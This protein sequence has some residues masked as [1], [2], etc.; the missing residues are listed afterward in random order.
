MVDLSGDGID[1]IISGSYWPGNLYVFRGSKD[2]SF[3]PIGVI[4]DGHRRN[5]NAGL[6]WRSAGE[7][8]LESLAPSPYVADVDADGAPDILVGNMCGT[9]VLIKNEG[10]VNRSYFVRKGRIQAGG[11][12]FLAPEG[13]SQPVMVDWD[14]DGLKDLIVG[15]EDGSVWFLRNTGCATEPVFERESPLVEGIPT[16]YEDGEVLH[17]DAGSAPMR[18]LAM[19]KVS[20]TDWNADGRM[21]LLVGDLAVHRGPDPELDPG[22]RTR[23]AALLARRKELS[24]RAESLQKQVPPPSDDD[25]R[26]GA[27]GKELG[28]ISQD[29]Q[30]LR[31]KLESHGFVWLHLRKPKTQ[32]SSEAR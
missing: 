11:E 13:H 31:G 7:P 4:K 26:F 17:F 18:P 20:V 14:G 5:V 27:I 2:G 9:V 25:P 3:G 6:P 22:G 12:D 24:Q 21:D 29:L 19:A 10:S 15:A 23:R 1:D 30:P 32:P 8:E 16:R 28:T